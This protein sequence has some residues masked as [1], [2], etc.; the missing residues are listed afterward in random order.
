MT[1]SC[2][3]RLPKLWTCCVDIV[4]MFNLVSFLENTSEFR[5]SSR[6]PEYGYLATDREMLYNVSPIAKVDDIERPLMVVH[7]AND[8][9][10]PINE[11]EQA[12]E[13]LRARGREILYLRYEDEG[14]GISKRKNRIDCYQ[15][16]IAFILEHLGMA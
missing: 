1:L 14:H 15:K 7:G 16:I 6:E 2:A 11:T 9:R 12:V 13:Q 5:R 8:P 10:V 4:G 3:A